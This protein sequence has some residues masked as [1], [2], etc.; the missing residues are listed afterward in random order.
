M[1][2]YQR[3]EDAVNAL[4]LGEILYHSSWPEIKATS[5]YAS[6]VSLK[7]TAPGT[8]IVQKGRRDLNDPSE[9]LSS[10]SQSQ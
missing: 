2:E 6:I 8:W 10:P 9:G 4:Q 7:T 1:K 3:L 5:L